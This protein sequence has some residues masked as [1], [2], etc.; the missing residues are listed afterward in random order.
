M[1]LL[2]TPA[3]ITRNEDDG[4]GESSVVV[5]KIWDR[6]CYCVVA[7][8]SANLKLPGRKRFFKVVCVKLRLEKHSEV[9]STSYRNGYCIPNDLM[10]DLEACFLMEFLQHSAV[11]SCCFSSCCDAHS[12]YL[13][14]C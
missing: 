1:K 12:M 8:E 6:E 13:R 10:H 3:S 5:P 11:C 7:L 2:Q 9:S 4:I 14:S